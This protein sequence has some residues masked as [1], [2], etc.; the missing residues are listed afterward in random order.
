MG[1]FRTKKTKLIDL[2]QGMTDIH[3]HLLP[4]I[5]DGAKDVAQSLSMIKLY[6]ELGLSG[7]I[8]TPHILKGAYP[9][10]PET[11]SNAFSSL[12]SKEDQFQGFKLSYAAEHMIDEEFEQMVKNKTVLPLVG[13]KVL[14]EMS[15][16][17]KP[18]GLK[19]ILFKLGMAGFQPI[20]AHPE[21]YVFLNTEREFADLHKICEFQVNALSL[22]NHYG[23]EVQ[24]KSFKLL[25][26][27]LYSYIGTD[28]H[29]ERH[30][31]KLAQIEIPNKYLKSITDIIESTKKLVR[32]I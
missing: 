10:T 23:P 24:K 7:A 15:Y 21:R 26:N 18:H 1:L 14:V 17:L 20:L 6:Q 29:H 11:I 32:D 2:M 30:L 25:Q 5:D 19:D 13:T 31:E 9:N 3:C 22:S 8:A 12:K 28:A 27:K 16:R 4:G